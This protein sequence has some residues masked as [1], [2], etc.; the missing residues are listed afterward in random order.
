MAE[1]DPTYFMWMEPGPR[2]TKVTTKV[3]NRSPCRIDRYREPTARDICYFSDPTARFVGPFYRF[4][5]V[6]VV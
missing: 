3:I 5:V 2:S 4:L 6:G 1:V